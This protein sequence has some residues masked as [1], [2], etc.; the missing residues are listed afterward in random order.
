M[1]NTL[2]Q[3]AKFFLWIVLG[4]FIATIFL[5]WGMKG[6]ISG[7]ENPDTVAEINEEPIS[8]SQLGQAWRNKLQEY[9]DDGIKVTE[10]LEKETKKNLLDDLIQLSLRLDYAKKINIFVTDEE[11]AQSIM[12][13]PAFKTE[14]GRFDQN[15]YV[16]FLYNQRI[17]P[18]DFEEQQRRQFV[19]LKL[20]NQLRADVKIT[21]DE[22]KQYFMKRSRQLNANYVYFNY[23]NF[24]K[25]IKIGE[26]RMKD[27]YALN[28][29]DY[30]KPERVKAS[31]ILIRPDASP[32]SPTGRTESQ[33]EELAKELIKKI[34][35]GESFSALAKKYSMDPGSKD[36]G[37]DLG[38]FERGRMVP[39]FEDVAFSLKKGELSGAIKTQFG[40][41]IIKCTGKDKGFKPTYKKVRL[42]VLKKLQ[43][44]EGMKLV[45][46]K[47]NEFRDA[48]DKPSDFE[49]LA[50]KHSVTVKSTGFFKE[51]KDLDAIKSSTYRDVIFDLNKG[52]V[53]AVIE[54][55]SGY[56][57][58]RI[59]GERPSKFS[60]K[61]F[62]EK[63]D[64]IEQ[65]L[66]SIKFDQVYKDLM[67][68][69]KKQAEIKIYEQN[70]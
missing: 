66:K 25:E 54:G 2:R 6:D 7:P 41:H 36:K 22:L 40:Y 46:R 60:D 39:Q 62:R 44:K 57:I 5:V 9:Y 34:N 15:L 56:Y 26:E 31:H 50:P 28:K 59:T 49:K 10:E 4:A 16:R 48:I 3:N 21:D 1:M 11:V 35:A 29:K 53:S 69:L 55:D 24:L 20:R 68:K 70:L 47:A 23:K 37:G 52:D 64:V 30:E 45:K 19:L 17:R 14:D 8:Y 58:F 12:Q 42:K 63:Y 38:W 51:D 27:Y 43:K 13:I 32:T 65:N 33:S 67:A 61:K 18:A